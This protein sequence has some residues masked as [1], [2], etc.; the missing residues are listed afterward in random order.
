MSFLV[1]RHVSDQQNNNKNGMFYRCFIFPINRK[2]V[3][4]NV[5]FTR[6]KCYL[7]CIII[8]FI[9]PKLNRTYKYRATT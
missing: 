4:K 2:P 8:F 7:H 9:S 1:V 6:D 3:N 5:L